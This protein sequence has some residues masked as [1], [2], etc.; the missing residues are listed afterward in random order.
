MLDGIH[1]PLMV[2]ESESFLTGQAVARLACGHSKQTNHTLDQRRKLPPG[3]SDLG[4]WTL[5]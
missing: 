1:S 4:Q 5:K 2:S 3:V